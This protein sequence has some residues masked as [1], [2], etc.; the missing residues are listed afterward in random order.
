MKLYLTG[1]AFGMIYQMGVVKHL[2]TKH[3]FT[4]I[5]GNSAGALLGTMVLLGYTDDEVRRIYDGIADRAIDKILSNPLDTESYRLTPHHFEVLQEI[6]KRYPK[7]YK[8]V[9]NKLCVGVTMK[10]GFKWFT[11]FRSNAELFNILLCSFHV[12]VLCS[13]NAIIDNEYCVDGGFGFTYSDLPEH[14]TT[15]SPRYQKEAHF[16]GH[17]PVHWCVLPPPSYIR[18]LYYEQ[19]F[20]DVKNKVKNEVKNK[21]NLYQGFDESIVPEFMWHKLREYQFVD[22]QYNISAFVE[23]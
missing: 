3:T 6:H 5:Y 19:G 16:N 14:I 11:K 22:K 15:V 2:R 10:S 12:P 4:K 7:A 20:N 21:V 23:H 9:S 13:Y 18:D 1:G 17:I 8:R